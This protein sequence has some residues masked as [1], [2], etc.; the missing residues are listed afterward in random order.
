VP[1]NSVRSAVERE[2]VKIDPALLP[3]KVMTMDDYLIETTARQQFDMLL[4]A[5]FAAVA[6]VLAASGIYG[7]MAYN[8]EQRAQ[9]IGIR[10]ALGAG[11]GQVTR[12]VLGQGMA[13]AGIGV[14]VG[15]GAAYGLTRFL[16]SLLYGIKATD[17]PT[18][19][20]IAVLLICV[21]LLAS[22]IPARRATRVDPMDALRHD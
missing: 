7:L 12:M 17:P 3:L 15:L 1:P 2:F 5:A 16:A 4:L 22:L 19:A 21:A 14:A 9:E 13:L 11:Q 8:V 20:Q 6:L 18:F 10:M